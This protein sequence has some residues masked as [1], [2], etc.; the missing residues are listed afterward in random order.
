[1]ASLP[2]NKKRRRTFKG[3]ETI[4]REGHTARSVFVLREGHVELTKAGERGAVRLTLLQAVDLFGETG[5]LDTGPR[6]ATAA[7]VGPV[8]VEEIPSNEFLALLRSDSELALHVLGQLA[9]RLRATSGQLAKAPATSGPAPA[10]SRPP[11]RAAS[12]FL[13]RFFGM[14]DDGTE[15]DRL[16]L[17]LAPLIG[18]DDRTHTKVLQALLSKRKGTRLRLGD[19][20][21]DLPAEGAIGRA[22]AV[23]RAAGQ[24]LA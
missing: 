8:T 12:G 16:S 15:R 23:T 18:D 24:W 11:P 7:A 4:F 14:P 22:Q 1:M 9:G 2:P 3:G 5:V 20:A 17:R 6:S 21:V 13:A 19:R 10:H